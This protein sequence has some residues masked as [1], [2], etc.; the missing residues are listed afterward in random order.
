MTRI[1]A[2]SDTH[3]KLSSIAIP[4]GDILI[5]AGDFT[6]QGTI[7]EI[8]QF[9]YNLLQ[10]TE[11]FKK[12][13]ICAGN[14]DRLFET[15]SN[16]AR[17][18]LSDKFLYLQDTG[19][20]YNGIKFWGSPWQ[21]EFFNWAFNLPRGPSLLEKWQLIPEDTDILIT[22]GPPMGIGDEVEDIYK[23]ARIN[24]G[25]TDLR[26]EILN[27]IRPKYHIAGHIHGGYGHRIIQNINFIN[28]S[29]LNENYKVQNE[30]IVFD[31]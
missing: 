5:H 8:A 30:P 19:Y 18:I 7:A 22:H 17:S 10:L 13:I 25:C 3:N 21:P 27:R 1:V 12:I 26:R 14:H 15:N 20:E 2:I 23:G 4:S 6:L 9:N 29:I 31:F 16:L 11:R 28:A 24:V